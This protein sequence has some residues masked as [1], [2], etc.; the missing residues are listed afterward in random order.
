MNRTFRACR[1]IR[2]YNVLFDLKPLISISRPCL[3]HGDFNFGNILV[4][5]NK[6]TVIDWTNARINDPEYDIAWVS[7]MLR[8]YAS[9]T[10]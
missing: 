5:D 9:D 1:N 2:I 6:I 10:I 7:A 3:I 4:S 8:V